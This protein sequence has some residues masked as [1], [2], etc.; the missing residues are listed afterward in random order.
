MQYD[1]LIKGPIE[2][3]KQ[4]YKHHGLEYTQEVRI[5][6]LYVNDSIG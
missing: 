2:V 1:D 6:V 4:I 5:F 3:V